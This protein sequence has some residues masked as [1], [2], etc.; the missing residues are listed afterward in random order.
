MSSENSSHLPLKLVFKF[1]LNVALVWALSVYLSQYFGLTGGIPAYVIVGALISLLNI[2]FRPIL[3]LITLPLRFFATIVA[4][5][6]VNGAFLY[7]IHLFT[8]RM[9]PSLV[10]LEIYGGPWGWVVVA[11]CF[12]F[13]NWLLKE[14]FK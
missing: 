7:V 10:R 9:D 3:N 2:F 11:I 14:M 13:A 6:I 1:A 5:I 4:V 8:L 12:G